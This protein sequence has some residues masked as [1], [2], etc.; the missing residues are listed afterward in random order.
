MRTNSNVPEMNADAQYT[1][2]TEAA[3][4]VSASTPKR[5]SDNMEET[6]NEVT[7]LLHQMREI[8]VQSAGTVGDEIDRETLHNEF[9]RIR[10]EMDGVSGSTAS[11]LS[12]PGDGGAD[13]G[14]LAV[15]AEYLGIG[16]AGVNTR[17]SALSAVAAVEEAINMVSDRRTCLS[18]IRNRVE[19]G[20]H[21]TGSEG[22]ELFV[23]ERSACGG[24]KAKAL[25]EYAA[26]G[27]LREI[28]TALRAQAN[29]LSENVFFL[30]V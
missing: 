4:G 24:D 5:F 3:T 15:S 13:S 22:G 1:A 29:L 10:K 27:I 12:P 14:S 16:S 19:R 17:E 30:L 9:D 2:K 26:D 28:P 8:A 7:D 20:S 11:P 21:I 6:L 23:I 25:T 18:V